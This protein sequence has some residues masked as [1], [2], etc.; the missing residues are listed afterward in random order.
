VQAATA[1]ATTRAR[2]RDARARRNSKAVAKIDSR[3]VGIERERENREEGE[4]FLP[5][6]SR[7]AHVRRGKA[8]ERGRR[9]E[10]EKWADGRKSGPSKTEDAK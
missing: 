5:S 10:G 7:A 9:A 6:G 3:R 2:A 1:A 8:V 4:S